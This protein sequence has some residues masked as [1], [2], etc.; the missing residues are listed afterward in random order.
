MAE[1]DNQGANAPG[2]NMGE[3]EAEIVAHPTAHY[4]PPN[5]KAE[6]PGEGGKDEEPT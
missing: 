6:G 4:I 3:T 1:T 5:E 2:V